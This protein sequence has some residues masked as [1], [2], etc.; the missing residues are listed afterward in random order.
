M[1]T[2]SARYTGF[3]QQEMGEPTVNLYLKVSSYPRKRA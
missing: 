2:V 3:P 1:S